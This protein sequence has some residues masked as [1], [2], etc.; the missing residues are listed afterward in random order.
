MLMKPEPTNAKDK[1]AVAVFKDTRIVG[2]VP[3]NLPPWLFQFLRRDVNKAFVEVGGERVNRG[4]GYGL[5]I[6]VFTISMAIQSILSR[7]GH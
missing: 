7:W 3:Q 1:Q 2:H 4:V 5:E 6:H